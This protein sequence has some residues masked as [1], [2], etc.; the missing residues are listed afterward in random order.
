MYSKQ[1]PA[2]CHQAPS[3]AR[4]I[5]LLLLFF[6]LVQQSFFPPFFAHHLSR[7]ASIHNIVSLAQVGFTLL[8]CCCCRPCMYVYSPARAILFSLSIYSVF[9]Y[10]PSTIYAIEPASLLYIFC[11][12]SLSIYW[13]GCAVFLLGRPGYWC[14]SNPPAGLP[15]GLFSYYRVVVSPPGTAWWLQFSFPP[16]S[17]KTISS[18][19]I[20]LALFLSIFLFAFLPFLFFFIYLI[21]TAESDGAALYLSL[22]LWRKPVPFISLVRWTNRKR[23][24]LL[25][26]STL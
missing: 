13:S 17:Q 12:S 16:E 3:F 23:R 19:F 24:F 1:D 14:R 5:F 22:S 9:W 21:G 8:G 4:L 6:S 11:S 20:F 25:S 7:W 18:I 2:E 10:C 15:L 26:I